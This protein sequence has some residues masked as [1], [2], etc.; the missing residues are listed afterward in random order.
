[1]AGG[2]SIL[3]ASLALDIRLVNAPWQWTAGM[4][5]MNGRGR[6]LR[7]AGQED[8]SLVRV[9]REGLRLNAN[10]M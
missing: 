10:L 4:D 5:F 1:M 3:P 2:E 9:G 8:A 7:K 6:N